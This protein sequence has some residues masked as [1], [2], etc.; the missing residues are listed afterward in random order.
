M[1]VIMFFKKKKVLIIKVIFK[2]CFKVSSIESIKGKVIVII[3]IK[4][5]Y[6]VFKVFKDN[7]DSFVKFF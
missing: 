6:V 7:D 2:G 1:I 4:K 3:L 5:I